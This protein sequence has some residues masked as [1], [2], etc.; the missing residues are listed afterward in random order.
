MLRPHKHMNLDVS[1]LRVAGLALK[2]LQ[3]RRVIDVETLRNRLNRTVRED[4]DTVL[5]P[6][7][8]VLFVLGRLRYHVKNDTLELIDNGGRDAA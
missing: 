5:A 3:K 4:V 8:S 7:L 1:A 2:E 6:A